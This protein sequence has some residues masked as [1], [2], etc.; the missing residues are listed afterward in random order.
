MPSTDTLEVDTDEWITDSIPINQDEIPPPIPPKE[1]TSSLN[2]QLQ[3]PPQLSK[4]IRKSED[5]DLSRIQSNSNNNDIL[6]KLKTSEDSSN[7]RSSISLSTTFQKNPLNPLTTIED[8]SSVVSKDSNNNSNNANSESD[9]DK[10]PKFLKNLQ[11]YETNNQLQKSNSNNSNNDLHH[12][13]DELK[14]ASPKIIT[15]RKSK[16]T[17][18]DVT[19]D[20][21]GSTI[22]TTPPPS[23]KYDTRLYSDEFYKDTKYRLAIMKRNIEF[24]QLFKS[25]DLTDRLL[26]DFSCAL[27]REILLQGR[28]YISESYICFNSNLLGWVTNLVVK[29]EDIIKFEK[30]SIA[31]LFPNGISIE[32]E[33]GSIHTFASF[34]SRDQTY[35]LMVTV[36][37]G[38]TG[39][40]NQE[41]QSRI[42]EDQASQSE[43]QAVIENNRGQSPKIHNYIMSLDGDDDVA[44]KIEE[45]E[46][47]EEE[48][49]GSAGT[50]EEDE[51]DED[52]NTKPISNGKIASPIKRKTEMSK[53]V[54]LKPESKYSNKGPDT[55]EPTIAKYTKFPQEIELIEENIQAPIG[56]VFNIL[57][58]TN[59][60]FQKEF[61]LNHDGSEI[62]EFNEFRPSNDDPTV[63]TREY[64]YR[65]NLGY[66]IGP[67]STRCEVIET[68]EHLNFADYIIV[69]TTTQT[70]DVPS[71]SVFQVKTRFVFTWGE[72]NSTNLLI[73]HYVDWKG[74]SW[75]KS[76]IEKSS[77]SGSTTITNELIK[78]LKKEI[79]ENTISELSKSIKKKKVKIVNEKHNKQQPTSIKTSQLQKDNAPTLKF[80]KLDILIILA[81]IIIFLQTLN[82]YLVYF[83]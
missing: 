73:S 76:V 41:N 11:E 13:T 83:K 8:A 56:I 54:K 45:E 78:E 47:E 53:I 21:I 58:G 59:D 35:D 61:L 30:R 57:F 38:K 9:N 65:R 55:H 28:T 12:Q 43:L 10:Q 19:F 4:K 48:Q 62:S 2:S 29:F 75:M 77:L 31:G 80:E 50:D 5:N 24:H 66:S 70:P 37:K 15:Y 17:S 18:S 26:D 1:I 20:S 64:T 14:L 67:K 69:T 22:P 68:I 36:W 82:L 79:E 39:R 63:L 44:A 60:K 33:D 3:K 72:N 51:I 49:N 32:T 25:L 6:Q 81:I 34:L 16:R 74:K 23:S 52:E 71:G 7:I 46:E 27:S 40:V 42:S